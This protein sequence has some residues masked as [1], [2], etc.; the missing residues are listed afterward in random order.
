MSASESPDPD[1]PLKYVLETYFR[2]KSKSTKDAIE[3]VLFEGEVALSPWLEERGISPREVTQEVAKDYLYDV[4]DNYSPSTQQ[5]YGRRVRFIY[6]KLLFKG[7]VG[8]D[9]NPFDTVLEQHD[10]LDENIP[11]ES[12]IYEKQVLQDILSNL[13]PCYFGITLT[14]AKTTRR[15][16]G[17]VNLDLC[18]VNLDHPAADWD[19]CSHVRP[20]D[21]HIY[22]GPKPTEGE[23]FRGEVRKNSA[24]TNTHTVIPIDEE[25][26]QT[27]VWWV[28]MR[29]GKN[30]EGPL[31]TSPSPSE[32]EHRVT[33]T[34]YREQ[35]TNVADN[36]GYRWD[37]YDPGNIR[38]HY[39]RHWTTSIMR[40]RVKRSIVD[41]FRGDVGNTGD[42]YDHYTP[43]KK[44]AWLN[45]IPQFL[46]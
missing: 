10:I 45:N 33:D 13:H 26:K 2:T 7:V 5:E 28:M 38:P 31:F 34:E 16:G 14:M 43:E 22:Y 17:T 18:D 25:L 11:N 36:L 19:L 44:K 46:D 24:K 40:D 1:D 9:T 3:D 32:H 29:R 8:I 12:P 15:I 35:L 27:L 23:K 6:S 30:D 20:Y 39:F 41:Y 37:S 4:K 42:G 21:D